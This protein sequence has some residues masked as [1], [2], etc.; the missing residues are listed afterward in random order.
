MNQRKLRIMVVFQWTGSFISTLPIVSLTI[1]N[2]SGKGSAGTTSFYF[3]LAVLIVV[4]NFF[5]FSLKEK[6]LH[7]K[8]LHKVENKAELP[9]F[10]LRLKFLC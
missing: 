4:L 7:M 5:I 8:I 10:G 3:D 9:V 1:F 2:A 6:V